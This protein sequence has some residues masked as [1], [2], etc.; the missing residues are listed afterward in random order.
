MDAEILFGVIQVL[1]L[2]VIYPSI[3]LNGYGKKYFNEGG[4]RYLDILI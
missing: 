3:C 2:R 4:N 1:N